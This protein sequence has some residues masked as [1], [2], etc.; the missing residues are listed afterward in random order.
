MAK[1][2]YVLPLTCAGLLAMAGALAVIHQVTEKSRDEK[3][4]GLAAIYF[5]KVASPEIDPDK[6]QDIKKLFHFVSRH[7]FDQAK[8][9]SDQNIRL[10]LSKSMPDYSLFRI[11]QNTLTLNAK[12]DYGYET[13]QAVRFIRHHKNN[14]LPYQMTC[15]G[16]TSYDEPGPAFHCV[17]NR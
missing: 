5:N 13:L 15:F 7:H 16:T 3:A 1:N 2:Q 14:A 6:A 11:E 9:L 12:R 4:A 8:F 10:D 17:L